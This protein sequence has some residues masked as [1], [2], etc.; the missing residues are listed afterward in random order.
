[1]EIIVLTID[2]ELE[3][4]RKLGYKTTTYL[5]D[6]AHQFD[7]KI[8]IR[9]GNSRWL[10]DTT[11]RRQA[12]VKNVV[13][14]A[15]S[16]RRNCEKAN[17]KKLMSQVV[18]VP[19]L[20]EKFVPAD[21]MAVVRPL[22]H[23]SGRGFS[24]QKGPFQVQDGTYATRYLDVTKEGAEYRVWFCGN[25]TM[26][27]KRYK[28]DCNPDEKFPC[29]SLWGYSFCDSISKELHVQTLLAA[30]KIGLEF[31]AADVLF[32]KGK[33]YFLELNSAASL[34]HRI[35]REFFQTNLKLLI[36]KKFSQKK[37]VAIP[38]VEEIKKKDEERNV[39]QTV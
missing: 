26:G 39:S 32:H 10:N 21:I 29:R 8:I 16:I 19:T 9:W 14:P 22:E 36:A 4:A 31:G 13:N 25:K 33:W 20:W 3:S 12:D 27:G 30:K 15:K 2:S 7:D 35:V 6:Y 1:M 38:V 37:E 17:S 11:G 23:S 5:G 18:N 28:M 24:V 34:D